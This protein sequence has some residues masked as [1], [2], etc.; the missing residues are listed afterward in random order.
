MRVGSFLIFNARWLG[1]GFLM[2]FAS[3]F[4]QT[5]FISLFGG[6]IRA[7]FGLSNGDFGLIYMGVTLVAALV[8]GWLG[9]IL[10]RWPVSRVVIFSI[11]TLACGAAALAWSASLPMLVASLFV[12][13][14]FG[15]GMMTHTAYTS[16]GRWFSAGRGR[17]VAIVA[18]GLNAGQALLPLL[19]VSGMAALGWRNIWLL[20]AV[21]LLTVLLP[22]VARLAKEDRRPDAA[23]AGNRV[24]GT[25]DWSRAEVLRDPCFYLLLLGMLPPAF[26]SN[27]IFFHQ[28]HLTE[29]KGWPAGIFASAFILYAV[30]TV[31]NALLSGYL[32]DRFSA[33]RLLPIYL[34]PM[35]M[36][37]LALGT[38]E[39]PWA[40]VAFLVLY[41]V[42]DGFSLTLFGSIWPEVYSTRYLGAIR[43]VIVA[44]M[45][46]A[47]ALG[48]GL[49]GVL[50]DAG[51]PFASQIVVMGI[52]CVAV[53]AVLLPV[54][55][56]VRA[57]RSG[58]MT[59]VSQ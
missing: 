7:D 59:V 29:T 2:L 4:G 38:I 5:F 25:K 8:L 34:L 47:S 58:D 28:I 32:V 39:A 18:L 46:F 19:A 43:A 27:A 6:Q 33:L 12:L 44:I 11:T 15:Q 3:S 31:V 36:G 56:R 41:G 52:Y 48:P 10:D 9:E 14:L 16:V 26:V 40:V 30:V 22:L 1:A 24:R 49:T 23:S 37:C 50:I 17:A 35:G 21:F 42:A 55:L 51:V 20:A 54:S 13:R 53:C 45:V 57:R